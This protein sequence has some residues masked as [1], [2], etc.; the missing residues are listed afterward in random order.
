MSQTQTIWFI[1]PDSIDDL[2]RVS[3][4]NLY[5]RQVR[6]GL[7]ARG[8][9]LR[10]VLVADG[11]AASEALDKIPSDGVA[12][13]D[14]L[15]AG[16]TPDATESAARRI[17]VVIIAHMISAAFPAARASDV[18]SQIRTLRA[19]S[20]IIA[21]SEWTAAEIIRVN[22][23]TA[24]R[25]TVASPGTREAP[26][27][28]GGDYRTF[29]CVG[30]IAPHKGQDVLLA[31]LD[32]LPD[33]EWRCIVVGSMTAD[34]GFAADLAA[35]ASRFGGRVKLPGLLHGSRLDLAYRRAGLLVAPSRTESFG[36][37]IL[38]ARGLGLPILAS[39]VGGIPEASS[40]GGAILIPP[41]DPRALAGALDDWLRNPVFRAVLQRQATKGS[42]T[43]PR[44][45]DTVDTIDRILVAA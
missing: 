29:L 43:V 38:D 21:T 20:R 34:R 30:A 16:W 17:P 5:D 25:V 12:L 33:R 26:R 4:G 14:G 40:G 36:M 19:A 15:V 35:A 27:P 1:V 9:K 10:V 45:S 23:A 31:A 42:A 28:R 39:A 24:G 6:Q 7:F 22:P 41:D 8:W 37:A 13:I 18:S 11:I 32:L 3:G 2:D 44:W